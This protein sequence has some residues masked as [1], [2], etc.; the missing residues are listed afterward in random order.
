MSPMLT[1]GSNLMAMAENNSSDYIPSLKVTYKTSKAFEDRK[2][3]V[4]DFTVDD[5]SYGKSLEVVALAYKLKSVAV[6]DNDFKGFYSA[7]DD[8]TPFHEKQ[9][10]KDFCAKYPNAKIEDGVEVLLYIP[11]RSKYVALLARKKLLEG[12]L[13]IINLSNG[14]K[15]V[16]VTNIVKEWNKRAWVVFE[17]EKTDKTFTPV[18]NDVCQLKFTQQIDSETPAI[19]EGEASRER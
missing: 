16:K 5:L 7:L 4:G 8:G 15:V 13:K 19:A 12:A 17:V 14:D 18:E 9:A 10:Y 1:V 2:A 6:E 11:D 3:E